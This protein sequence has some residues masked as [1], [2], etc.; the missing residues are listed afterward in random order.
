[1]I[2]SMMAF[3]LG[4]TVLSN[5]YMG[6]MLSHLLLPKE[7][8]PINTLEE[9]A[10]SPLSW[11]A[12]RGTATETLFM[13]LTLIHL[14]LHR[15]IEFFS[16]RRLKRRTRSTGTSD[17]AYSRTP[18][19]CFLTLRQKGSASESSSIWSPVGATLTSG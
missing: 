8:A 6:N 12:R 1:M 14:P 16:S 10:A 5:A 7:N 9:L 19:S 2:V 15:F 11:V 3:I 17:G 4:A 13:V 18:M